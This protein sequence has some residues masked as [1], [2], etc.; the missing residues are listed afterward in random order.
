MRKARLEKDRERD[1][2]L[3]SKLRLGILKNETGVFFKN[4]KGEQ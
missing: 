3:V 2:G 1:E 4:G